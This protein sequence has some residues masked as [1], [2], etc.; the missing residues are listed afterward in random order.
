MATI[1]Q[2]L[3]TGYMITEITG[4]SLGGITGTVPAGE[5]WLIITDANA[6]IV[7]ASMTQTLTNNS[8]SFIYYLCPAGSQVLAVIGNAVRVKMQVM[9]SINA[10]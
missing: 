1:Y 10:L 9:P 5:Q 8:A 4:T 3:T 2:L 7:G 6:N